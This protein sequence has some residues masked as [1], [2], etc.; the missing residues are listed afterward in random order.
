MPKSIRLR[1]HPRPMH[2]ARRPRSRS[3][4]ACFLLLA[5]FFLLLDVWLLCAVFWLFDQL[6]PSPLC[7]LCFAYIGAPS[8]PPPVFCVSIGL[9]STPA[10][11]KSS[12]AGH[13]PACWPV[14]SSGMSGHGRQAGHAAAH[15]GLA[16]GAAPALRAGTEGVWD[17]GHAIENAVKQLQGRWSCPGRICV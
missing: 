10:A 15:A 5:G 14:C 1:H 13:T 11:K 4:S 9:Q 6:P 3:R 12:P 2:D 17:G 7:C 8:P 16:R